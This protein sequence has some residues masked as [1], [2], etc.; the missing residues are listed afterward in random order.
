MKQFLSFVYY[1]YFTS[2]FAASRHFKESDFI[3]FYASLRHFMPLYV[4]LLFLDTPIEK[5]V[6]NENGKIAA[7]ERYPRIL[8]FLYFRLA[9]SN[10]NSQ[11]DFGES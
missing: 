1:Y 11:L 7:Q 10:N 9:N 8:N 4:T 2:N 5:G 3:I 6:K